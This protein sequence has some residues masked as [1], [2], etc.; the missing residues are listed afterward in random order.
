MRMDPKARKNEIL[1]AAVALATKTGG[2]GKLT[3]KSVAEKAGC[4]EALVSRY[5]N[6][7]SNLKR[8][9]MRVAVKDEILSVIGQGVAC[10]DKIALA[11]PERLYVAAIRNL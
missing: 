5:F 1:I 6:T 9:V 7:V 2:F 11:V 8:A 10:G 4:S 3:R